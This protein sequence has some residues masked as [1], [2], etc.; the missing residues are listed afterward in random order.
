MK[1][2]IIKAH[3][4]SYGFTH[5]I[6]TRF[7]DSKEKL[8]SSVEILDLYDEK[9]SLD[10]LKF[11]NIREDFP[12]N[13]VTKSL[14]E[15]ISNADELVFIFPMWNLT[16]PAILKNFFDIIFCARFGF[17]YVEGKL[18]PVGLLN[19]KVAHFFVTCDGYSIFYKLMGN[20]L[21]MIWKF[22]RMGMCKIKTKNF[23]Y[24]QRMIFAKDDLRE[25]YLQKVE[26]IASKKY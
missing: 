15:K 21:K 13:L 14:K 3:P 11:E 16:E 7:K 20:P 2:L 26:K 1:T 18:F 12:N 5:K 23:V 10:L 19:G 9:Y 22:G 6:A 17:K 25:K 24:F 8:G 4:A